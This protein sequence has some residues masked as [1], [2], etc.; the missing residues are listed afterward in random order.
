MGCCTSESSDDPSETLLAPYRNHIMPMRPVLDADEADNTKYVA[1]EQLGVRWS[2]GDGTYMKFKL[3]Q[4]S[5]STVQDLDITMEYFRPD[6]DIDEL[7]D[8]TGAPRD[9]LSEFRL[10][11]KT[12]QRYDPLL[13]L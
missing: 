11:D 4:E 6:V 10:C 1:V 3:I 5:S 9:I 8:L 13:C 2:D 12:W 7:P